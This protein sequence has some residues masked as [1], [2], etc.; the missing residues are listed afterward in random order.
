ML[1]Q[2]QPSLTCTCNS[3]QSFHHLRGTLSNLRSASSLISSN[4]GY[5]R[6]SPTTFLSATQPSSTPPHLTSPTIDN[7][8]PPSPP[9]LPPASHQSEKFLPNTQKIQPQLY[10]PK[11]SLPSHN[12]ASSLPTPETITQ[13]IHPPPHL[14]SVASSLLHA[15]LPSSSPIPP[16]PVMAPFAVFITKIPPFQQAPPSTPSLSSYSTM[17]IP[18]SPTGPRSLSGPPILSSPSPANS[19]ITLPFR[20]ARRSLPHCS[21]AVLVRRHLSLTLPLQLHGHHLS[22]L[23]SQRSS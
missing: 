17:N 12:T 11:P 18:A 3:P 15:L 4:P 22:R 23:L 9:H 1:L 6:P 21:A 5:F 8:H 20:S 2:R 14:L 13:K 16:T 19:H 7:T 10:L